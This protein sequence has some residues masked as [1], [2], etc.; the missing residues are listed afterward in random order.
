[1][2]IF[3]FFLIFFFWL[4]FRVEKENELVQRSVG[5]ER[6]SLASREDGLVGGT[7]Y[8]RPDGDR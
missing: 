1:M 6:L 8:V 2:F 5:R 4:D 3:L 7:T